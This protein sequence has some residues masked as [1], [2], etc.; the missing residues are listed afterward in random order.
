[1]FSV[2][3]RLGVT[4]DYGQG[5]FGVLSNI[6]EMKAEKWPGVPETPEK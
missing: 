4:L 2:C 5:L 1:M 6:A 3:G